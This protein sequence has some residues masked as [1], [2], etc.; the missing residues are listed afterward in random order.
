V[1]AG[2]SA[3]IGGQ[4][5]TPHELDLVRRRA[6][7]LMFTDVRLSQNRAQDS[8]RTPAQVNPFLQSLER[9]VPLD[10]ARAVPVARALGARWAGR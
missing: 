5:K 3:V 2:L 1:V 10:S 9:A 6:R 8:H 7:S 4:E